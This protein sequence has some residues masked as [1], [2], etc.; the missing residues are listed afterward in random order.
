MIAES[1]ASRSCG[2]QGGF[3][4]VA[5]LW[6]LVIVAIAAGYFSE[7]VARSV[8]LAQ[9]SRQN[10][11]AVI[12]MAGTRAEILYRLGTTSMTEYGLGRGSAAINLDDRPYRGLGDTLIRLQDTR[13]LLNLNLTDDDRLQRFLGLLGIAAERRGHL[14]DT[15]RDYID[16][17][18][19]HRLNGAE[20]EEYLALNLPP[21]AN[22]DLLTPWEA[23]RIIGW[24][25]A[26]QLWQNA[27]L[28]ELS[29]VGLSM[30]INPNTA[31]AEV[32][33]TLPGVT[34][35][36]AQIIMARRKL[37]P[38]THEGQVVDITSVPLNFPIGM[39]IIAIPSDTL[40]ITQSGRGLP[41]AIQ[42]SIKLTPNGSDAPWRTDYYSRVPASP[43][44]E[45]RTDITELAPRSSAPPD[46]MPSFLVP[47]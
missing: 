37:A 26:P 44:V 12:D 13:G 8:A 43:R 47:G 31:P 3:V 34:E 19:L 6:V 25:D 18:K 45:E 36:M 29:T 24:R 10:T 21:P 20:D 42:Y 17:D 33:A 28:V 30:G 27:R 22:R 46:K 32:L 7:R 23:R 4:L 39:G 40:R 35:E 9:Q 1:L 14:I 38:I 2:R 5:T 15:L 16:A 41:W 11:R